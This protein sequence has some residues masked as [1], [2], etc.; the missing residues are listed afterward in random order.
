M[1]EL[2]DDR[3]YEGHK[4]TPIIN[5]LVYSD[6][7]GGRLSRGFHRDTTFLLVLLSGTI[8]PIRM[9]PPKRSNATNLSDADLLLF[10]FLFDTSPSFRHLRIDD[11]SFH[12][13]CRYSH[14]LSD[15]NLERTMASL[16]ER[17]FVS[18]RIGKIWRLD[19]QEFEDGDIYTLTELGGS[20]WELER[21][22]DCDKFLT[23]DQWERGT[24]C[25][26]M[27]RIVCRSE[28]I[29]RRCLGSMFAAGLLSPMGRIR[30]RHL[31]S[32]SLLPWKTFE[33][34]VSIRCKTNGNVHDGYIPVHWNVYN[35]NRCWW[36]DIAE[37]DS[38]GSNSR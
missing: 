23:T 17:G 5:I 19:L 33:N 25:R 16:I 11:Y 12:M 1:G 20:L 14:G 22:P 31:Q 15:P 18:S 2:S 4:S 26:G 35:A 7:K 10:D 13:N 28:E 29:G 24:N 30:V 36:R 38:L 9:Q 37:L 3:F 6:A 8:N 32:A 21:L 34:V 27:M